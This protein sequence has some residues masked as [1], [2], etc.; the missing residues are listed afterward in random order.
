[1]YATLARADS[2]SRLKDQ[3]IEVE[4]MSPWRAL[5]SEDAYVPITGLDNSQIPP[6]KIKDR[7]IDLNEMIKLTLGRNA[8][9][10]FSAMLIIAHFPSLASYVMIFATS[11]T[12]NVPLTGAT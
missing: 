9:I 8:Q 2:I 3:G 6:P 11:F 10:F 4:A 1:M 12:A 5:S 7:R